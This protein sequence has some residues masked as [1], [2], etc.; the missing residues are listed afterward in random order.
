ML[1]T[2]LIGS[3]C[4][5][6]SAALF[7]SASTGSALG[8]FVLFF[9]SPLP[10]A[11]AGLGWNSRAALVG[12]LAGSALI[13]AVT[14]GRIAGPAFYALSLAAPGALL[15]HLA[16]LARPGDDG[17]GGERLEWYPIGRLI[18]IAAVWAGLVAALA[19]AL[20][21]ADTDQTRAQFRAAVQR[22][23][24]S[25]VAVPGADGAKVTDADIERTVSLVLAVMPGVI[26][27]IWMLVAMINLWL[28]GV[29]VSLSGLLKRPWPYL[30]GLALPWWLATLLA[31][32]LVAM[33][34]S[35][36]PGVVA[37]C[38]AAAALT[39]YMLGGLAIL[40]HVTRGSALRPI[41]LSSAYLSLVLVP[42]LAA[43]VLAVIALAE[44]ISP[45]NRRG[46]APPPPT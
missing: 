33:Y 5:L 23:I 14:S 22:M 24:S 46:G 1:V 36:L 13:Y 6:V 21:Y 17:R 40:H 4:G 35:G 32:S 27:S 25:G 43:L 42:P 20:V 45:L 16:L 11:I 10:I 29:V 9:L 44:P 28:A 34:M 8:V 19:M 31:A 39:A 37:T 18:A 3:L 12:M 41:V 26:A 15:A 38:F 7:L 2:V 30:P